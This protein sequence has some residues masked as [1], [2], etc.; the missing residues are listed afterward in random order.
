M[1][2][3]AYKEGLRQREEEYR[4]SQERA[5]L[6]A[7]QIARRA[8]R[9]ELLGSDTDS[10]ELPPSPTWS[11]LQLDMIQAEADFYMNSPKAGSE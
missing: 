9:R 7:E 8:K 1:R 2:T 6:K 4:S 10:D 5:R 11:E 3:R